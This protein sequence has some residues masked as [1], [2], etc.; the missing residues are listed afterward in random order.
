ML[1]SQDVF[2]VMNLIL[3]SREKRANI[4]LVVSKA[5]EAQI[6]FIAR[7]DYWCYDYLERCGFYDITPHDEFGKKF[8]D[9]RMKYRRN[10]FPFGGESVYIIRPYGLVEKSLG[11]RIGGWGWESWWMDPYFK[12]T[13]EK[14]KKD[15]DSV[16]IPKLY[17]DF[18]RQELDAL[19][20]ISEAQ[21][22]FMKH[23]CSDTNERMI[24]ALT[25][26]GM[27][28]VMDTL[29]TNKESMDKPKNASEH[30]VWHP[31]GLILAGRPDKY[32]TESYKL[33][34]SD[35]VFFF[36][37]F[38]IELQ[39]DL[40][41]REYGFDDEFYQAAE[42]CTFSSKHNVS[43]IPKFINRCVQKRPPFYRFR[44]SHLERAANRTE[45][46]PVN[47][48]FSFRGRENWPNPATACKGLDLGYLKCRRL[49][50]VAGA[51]K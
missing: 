8:L 25:A 47:V 41:L 33:M 14:Y 3:D 7:N 19:K 18:S 42:R 6:D 5:V 27:L 10:H 15:P 50:G 13:E 28:S 20:G 32:A 4:R 29:I 46:F 16:E 40:V 17:A 21:A 49:L 9:E 24:D 44:P 43:Y 1:L 45:V 26:P 48:R 51:G 12:E 23:P 39:K 22:D 36:F 2:D 30:Y 31:A 38:L 34:K 37:K 35:L 11:R